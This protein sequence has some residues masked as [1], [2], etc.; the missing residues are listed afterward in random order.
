MTIDEVVK[1]LNSSQPKPLT[2]LQEWLLRQAWEGK[3]YTSMAIEANYVEEYLRK[4][5]SGLWSILTD[6][7]GEPITKNNFRTILE[8]RRLTKAQRQLIEDFTRAANSTIPEFPSGPLS[9]DSQFYIVRPPIEQL[10]YEELTK[11][12]SIIRIKAPSKFGK[13]SLMLRLISHANANKYRAVLVDFQ[14][15]EKAVFSNLNKFLRWFCANVSRELQLESKLDDYWDEDV[16]SK[17]SCTLYFESY[18]LTQISSPIVLALNEGNQLFDYPEIARD[19]LPLLRFWHEQAKNVS[20]WQKLRTIFAYSTEI[21]IPI[22]L[23]NSPFNIGLPLNLPPFNLEQVQELAKRYGLDWNDTSKAKRLMA[24]VGGHPYLVQLAFYHFYQQEITLK[25]LLEQAITSSSGIYND[26]LL[27]LLEA[28][29]EHPNLKPALKQVIDADRP[30]KID[31]IVAKKLDSMGLVHLDGAHVSPSCELYR[32]YFKEKLF[33]VE[34]FDREPSPVLKMAFRHQ[35]ETDTK[36]LQYLANLDE[37]TLVANRRYFNLYLQTEWQRSVRERTNLSLILCEIDFFK[38]FHKVYGDAAAEQC[39]RQV[40]KAMDEVIQAGGISNLEKNNNGDLI[41]RYDSERFVILLPNADRDRSLKIAESI[42]EKIKALGIT[43]NNFYL[44]IGGFPSNA[45][46]ISVGVSTAISHL[47]S[48]YNLLIETAEKA[49]Y[50]SKR[51]GRD[52]VTFIPT[53]NQ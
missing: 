6:L 10:A 51:E 9:V 1:F 23:N 18:L 38:T 49:L 19:F 50:Q 4:T 29:E 30:V 25:Q 34:E 32:L 11:P 53:L 26:H 5:A 27:A 43:T 42:R 37:I 15:A 8:S 44:K 13:S 31:P 52:R 36:N 16:G 12:G 28:L 39:L 2:A 46:S 20:A 41:A 35:L 24:M 17:V 48:N 45:I 40:A 14:Q 47:N 3:T 7:C 21:Y 22:K 33:P